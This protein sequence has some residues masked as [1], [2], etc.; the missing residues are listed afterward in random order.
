MID[1]NKCIEFM[2]LQN[3]INKDIDM[4]GETS[5]DKAAKLEILA[6][7]MNDEEIDWILEM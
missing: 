7:S 2:R 3:S 5:Y 6:D 4:N 1:L